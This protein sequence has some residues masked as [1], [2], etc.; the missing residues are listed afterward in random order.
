MN[1]LQTYL[2]NPRTQR[3][4]SRK[5]GEKGFSLIELVVVIAVL[6]VLTA[7]A[8]PNFL[9]VSDDAAARAAQ[10]AAI[11]AFKECQ[12]YKARGQANL[13]PIPEMQPPSISD[14]VVG[15]QAPTGTYATAQTYAGAGQATAGETELQCFTAAGALKP[16]YAAP[17]T[18]E[19]F[20][21]FRV[22]TG[23]IRQCESG[24]V[25]AGTNDNTFN[26][27]CSGTT[28]GE[29]NWL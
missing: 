12:V 1:L 3:A 8:L 24:F 7:I 16:V 26:I 25:T 21:V 9:G 15:T 6:A 14:F 2:Q 23:G 5:P 19:K 18:A 4:L 13:T 27:G 22:T 10:Q 17:T 28:G 20:P 29:G 11:T